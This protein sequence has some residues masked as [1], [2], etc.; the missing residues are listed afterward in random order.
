MNKELYQLMS[1][2]DS[3]NQAV[4]NRDTCDLAQY[5]PLFKGFTTSLKNSMYRACISVEQLTCVYCQNN[6]NDDYVNLPCNHIICSQNC[7]KLFSSYQL[8]NELSQYQYLKCLCNKSIPKEITINV[9]GGIE[10]FKKII[11]EAS[12]NNINCTICCES[13]PPELF[14]TLDCDHRF[15]EYC[16]KLFLYNLISDGKVGIN[17]ACPECSKPVD[18]QIILNLLDKEYKEKYEALL[19][20]EISIHIPGEVFVR[21]V[22]SPGVNCKYGQYMSVDRD[23]YT[24]PKCNARFCPKCRL[25]VH[26][27]VTCEAHKIKKNYEQPYIREALA[28]G[29]MELCPWCYVPIEK[30]PEGC[31]YMTCRSSFCRGKK[32][33]C[34]DCK[35][36]L[37]KFHQNHD[38][39][40]NDPNTKRCNL[41]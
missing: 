19:L 30:D 38:C 10:K 15:C 17:I 28:N 12:Y 24:C 13:L 16:V 41:F 18:P 5:E 2:M 31:K 29:S 40:T 33:F 6:L 25:D 4:M 3:L 32:Y 36:K 22:S 9:Y 37:F 21:C 34:W 7:F 26:P 20:D 23:D 8:I 27:N 11:S 35:K 39:T 14:I 1:L